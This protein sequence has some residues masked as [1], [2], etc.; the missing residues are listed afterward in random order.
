MLLVFKFNG[1]RAITFIIKSD[2]NNDDFPTTDRPRSSRV[3]QLEDDVLRLQSSF[4][5]APAGYSANVLVGSVPA[6]AGHK[7]RYLKVF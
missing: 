5:T 7:K 4:L 3:P 1:S 2:L 6:F